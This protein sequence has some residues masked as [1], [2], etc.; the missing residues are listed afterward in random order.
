VVDLN[1]AHMKAIDYLLGGGDSQYINLGTGDGNS[2]LEIVKKV[3]EVANYKFDIKRSEVRKG[4]YVKMVADITK[5]KEVLGWE[6][7][8]K[9]EDSINSLILWYKKHPHGWV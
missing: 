5:A 4:E 9:I 6:P 7:K 2:V 3:G 8:R 1:E